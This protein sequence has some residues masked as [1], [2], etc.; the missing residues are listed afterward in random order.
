MP[1]GVA[2]GVM[3]WPVKGP[4]A[5]GGWCRQQRPAGQ[6]YTDGLF[7]RRDEDI[8]VG[9]A[10]LIDALAPYGT[11]PLEELADGLRDGMGVPGGGQDDGSALVVV[12]L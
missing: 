7:E 3:S 12:R 9:L 10:R 5:G 4:C 11:L 1:S 6:Y 2:S 8:D